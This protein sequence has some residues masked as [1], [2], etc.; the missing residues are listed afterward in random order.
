M[1]DVYC[2]NSLGTNSKSPN[3]RLDFC[4]VFLGGESTFLFSGSL[5]GYYVQEGRK[6]AS[7]LLRC[8]L[9]YKKELRRKS[10][11]QFQV[12]LSSGENPYENGATAP[13]MDR[14]GPIDILP[15]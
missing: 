2:S 11:L 6:K 8:W 9:L 10:F 5:W 7:K 4:Y 1:N 14:L 15:S 12:G 13:N 3:S